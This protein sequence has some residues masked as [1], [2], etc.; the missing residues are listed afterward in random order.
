MKNYD[1]SML[2]INLEFKIY[3]VLVKLGINKYEGNLFEF[4]EDLLEYFDR[5]DDIFKNPSIEM[6]E[7]HVRENTFNEITTSVLPSKMIRNEGSLNKCQKISYDSKIAPDKIEM[8]YDF[9]TD[10]EVP[11]ILLIIKRDTRTETQRIAILLILYANKVI[12]QMD[13]MSSQS[14]TPILIKSDIDPT[15]SN[16]A[17]RGDYSKFIKIEGKTYRITN[18]GMLKARNLIREL[19]EQKGDNI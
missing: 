11:P 17:F 8:V 14:L 6:V 12:N 19:V 15:A 9:G 16:K 2:D 5:H 4:L 3:N 1:I 13:K 10:D 7:P 18:Q